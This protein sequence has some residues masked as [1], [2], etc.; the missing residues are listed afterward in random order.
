VILLPKNWAGFQHYKD[1][2]PTWIRLHRSLLDNLEFHAL[3]PNAAKTLVLLWLVAA[4]RVDGHFDGD[5]K[6]LSFRLRMRLEDV[7]AAMD[8]LLKAGFFVPA[9]EAPQE[10]EGKSLAQQIREKNG[11]GSRHISDRVKRTVWERDGGKCRHCEA[12]EDIEFDHIHPV[13]KGGGSSEE[14]VQ[15]LCRPCNRKKRVKTA[16]QV[17][18]PAQPWLSLRTSETETETETETKKEKR[19]ARATRFALDSLPDDWKAFCKQERPDLTPEKTFAA[20]GDYWRGTPGAKGRKLD[21]TATW[22]NWV[23]NEKRAPQSRADLVAPKPP[24]ATPYV[25]PEFVAPTAETLKASQKLTEL[26]RRTA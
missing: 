25:G 18:T 19:E 4:E 1:R 9:E 21:W 16:E 10:P 6:Y 24:S 3:S 15:L 13:S 2:N 11:F 23:R 22:R 5:A 20:F 7:Q 8:E 12:T 17:G 14:N 26:L